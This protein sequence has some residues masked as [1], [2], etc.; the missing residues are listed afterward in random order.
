MRKAAAAV[1][2][3]AVWLAAAGPGPAFPQ[4]TDKPL[5]YESFVTIKLLQV[6]VTG[7]KGEP[8][9]DLRA[10][11]FEILDNG[12]R[13]PVS[14]FEKHFIETETARPKP[15]PACALA[16]A[17]PLGR[18]FFLVFD[19]V[20]TDARGII[21][22]KSA[23]L[24]FLDGDIRLTDE[25]GV[26][27]YTLD[28]GLVI[29]EY[30]TADHARVRA[31]VD[32]FGARPLAGRAESFTHHLFTSSFL[33]IPSSQQM[34]GAVPDP[35][36]QFYEGQAA[37]WG[38]VQADRGLGGAER[39]S[40]VDQAQGLIVALGQMAKVLRY[41]PGFKNVILFSGGIARQ[42]IYGKEGGGASFG[43]WTTPD[44][45]ASQLSKYDSARGDALLREEHIKMLKE[46][47]ASNCPVYSIDIS[48]GRKEIDVSAI[49]GASGSAIREFEG[50]DSLRQFAG[51]TG[52]R[53][54]ANTMESD[55]IVEDIQKTTSG[56]YVLGYSVTEAWDEAFHKI[57]VKVDRRGV[58]V[59]T[60]GGYFNP[61]PFNKYSRFEKLLHVIDLALGDSP[62][63]AAEI[64]VL[65]LPLTLKG[66][67]HVL[68]FARV[69]RSAHAAFLGK[70]AE[71][72]FLLM[73]ERGDMAAARSVMLEIPENSRGT[74]FPS[75]VAPADPGSYV[76]R[77]VLR[78]ID[79]GNGVRGSS[80]V[81][82][83]ERP[84]A[85]FDIDPPLLLLPDRD[86][87]DLAAAAGE[88]L[89]GFYGYDPNLYAPFIGDLTAGAVRLQAAL[90]IPGGSA[91]IEIK[92]F[93]LAPAAPAPAEIP[94]SILER[95]A[96]GK[97]WIYLAEISPG[98]LA[99][100]RFTL[101][102]EARD[103]RTGATA[104]SSAA[105]TVR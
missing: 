19:F 97:T 37:L 13:R 36:N 15:D 48:R 84:K 43:G 95:S 73:N 41:I 66:V 53:F 67:P 3:A 16:A 68:V 76:A 74:V 12:K 78:D 20:L 44:Q 55:R 22:A 14:H 8:V 18:K 25:I 58:D 45:L 70:G 29:H 89:S 54:Y 52:G 100:G 27:S 33:S 38:R 9:T 96:E 47:K 23:A 51:E 90:R 10:A 80:P 79:T 77:I 75:F 1:I 56:Y 61:K 39:R 40:Y 21:K 83:P 59:R 88:S 104:V 35:E 50:A 34:Q 102:I 72:Y 62:Q 5:Q 65:A 46:F 30:F 98:E 86:A 87:L 105:F 71:A 4:E 17:P 81:F 91:G 31:I 64:P 94:V 63:T 103:P 93:L 57:K 2:G 24:E 99:S 82:V 28:R 49:G 32:G 92:A 6:Y 42:Y 7:K 60:Q 11:D 85:D 101:K 69:S 26:V